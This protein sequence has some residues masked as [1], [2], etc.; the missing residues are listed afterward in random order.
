MGTH[1]PPSVGA[2]VT[3]STPPSDITILVRRLDFHDSGKDPS[4]VTKEVTHPCLKKD[5][6]RKKIPPILPFQ[7]CPGQACAGTSHVHRL[8]SEPG[9]PVNPL[10]GRVSIFDNIS[11]NQKCPLENNQ[12]KKYWKQRRRLFH[13]FDQGIQLDEE[14]WF[15]VTPEQIADHVAYH[16]AELTHPHTLIL[17]DA[18]GGCGGNSI[19]FAKHPNIMVVSVDVDRNKLRM[20][21][22]NAGIYGIPPNQIVF[23]ECNVLFILEFCFRDGIFIL[24]QPISSPEAAQKLMNAMPPPTSSETYCGYTI[25]GIDRLPRRIDAVFM[26]PPWGG[27][28][29]QVFGKNGYDLCKNMH[30]R[31]PGRQETSKGDLNADFF[32]CFQPQTKEERKASF[33]H[34]ADDGHSV[35]GAE[36][37]KLAAA[38]SGRR[39]VLYDVPRNTNR[40]SLANAALAAGFR[41]NCK[42]EE[43]YLNGTLK[44]VTAYFGMDWTHLLND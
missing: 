44:T 42:L 2:S 29:Y 24:D 30:I 5:G 17:L 28:D 3:S 33:N 22:H 43:H 40:T 26:D 20:A 11:D 27:I 1:T 32:D 35:N 14:G 25:G 19:A 39:L 21:A 12:L 7:Y 41:G 34:K 31:R 4:V 38:A 18:F 16:L 15:S 10:W 37:L 23:I 9:Q 8:P 36:L 6:T 13:R